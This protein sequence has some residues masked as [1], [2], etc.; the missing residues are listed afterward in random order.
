MPFVFADGVRLHY[1]VVGSGSPLLLLPGVGGS[2]ESWRQEMIDLLAVKFSIIVYS[3]RG[4]G[5][6]DKPN[7]SY[8]LEVFADD[9]AKVIE[10]CGRG[11]A[12]ILGFSMGGGVAQALAVRHPELVKSLIICASGA[13]GRPKIQAGDPES[14]KRFNLIYNPPVG[15]PRDFAARILISLLYPEEYY[16]TREEELVK[17]EIYDMHPTPQFVLQRISSSRSTHDY[18]QELP[19]ISVPVLVMAGDQDKLNNSENCRILAETIPGA[20]LRIFKE[21]GH[22]FLKQLTR[23]AVQEIIDFLK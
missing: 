18:H 7:D 2:G 20:K 22:G 19:K 4:T 8:N 3:P 5:M 6:S 15:A 21:A 10:G 12:N 17:E 1:Y 14:R 9:A 11:Q 23:E 16:K 13:L